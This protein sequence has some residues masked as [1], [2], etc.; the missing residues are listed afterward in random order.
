MLAVLGA[1]PFKDKLDAHLARF[2]AE[3]VDASACPLV[4]GANT[5]AAAAVRAWRALALEHERVRLE[6]HWRLYKQ[7][8]PED[9][10]TIISQW[11]REQVSILFEPAVACPEVQRVPRPSVQLQ[12]AY[13]T[14]KSLCA[15]DLISRPCKL[16]S[17]GCHFQDEEALQC[18]SVIVDPSLDEAHSSRSNI[19]H[20]S[21]KRVA[22]R[23]DVVNRSVG[24][25]IGKLD[26][27]G[28]SLPLVNLRTL[29]GAL[30]QG[31][32]PFF[33]SPRAR[34]MGASCAKHAV[35]PRGA[36]IDVLNV[37]IDG[38]EYDVVPEIYALCKSGMLTVDQLL[39]QVQSGWTTGR[40]QHD[41]ASLHAVFY[42]AHHCQL[43]LFHRELNLERDDRK[44]EFSW[45][46]MRHV[47]RLGHTHGQRRAGAGASNGTK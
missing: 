2:D 28:K 29:L 38:S 20:A 25:G 16:V 35:S 47:L 1:S 34:H 33:L 15:P 6:T 36:P 37:D 21:G 41:A 14:R 10:T 24:I 22:R 3:L 27:A 9:N 5:T 7:F 11:G 46:S 43:M 45:V 31:S 32:K 13:K 8:M 40:A 12:G 42:G 18:R 23:G 19:A 4:T 26:V 39:V 44:T 30:Q 17:L